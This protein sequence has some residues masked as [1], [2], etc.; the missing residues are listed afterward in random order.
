MN[1][2]KVGD[3]VKDLLS[4]NKTFNNPTY[5]QIGV[6]TSIKEGLIIVDFKGYPNQ[7]YSF[8]YNL[9]RVNST[10]IKERLGII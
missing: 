2:L 4:S 5:G 6:V 7:R 1:K 8:E 9:K 10:K 3:N